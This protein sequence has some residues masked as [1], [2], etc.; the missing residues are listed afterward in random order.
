[1]ETN[2]NKGKRDEP[3]VSVITVVYNGEQHIERT[4]QSVFS[5]SYGNIEYIVIEGASTDTTLTIIRK[6]AAKISHVLSERD[7]GLYHAMNKGI[8][9][10][11]GEIIGILNSGDVYLKNTVKEI[12][13]TNKRSDADIFYGDWVTVKES[14]TSCSYN[15]EYSDMKQM[16]YKQSI[17]HPTCFVKKEVY[18]KKGS[19]DTN[20]RL[21]AD[22]DFLLR[23]MEN[24][25]RFQY[26]P[27]VITACMP[28]GL[29]NS[30]QCDFEA[31]RIQ[32]E[33][34]IPNPYKYIYRGIKCYAKNLMEK[35]LP[36]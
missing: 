24:N 22:Y 15:R 21:A 12:V 10:A 34:R 26:I 1:M 18:N 6:H 11:K 20:Y 30:W 32:K 7:K 5:Q 19:F 25:M 28:G 2:N 31:F 9:L 16:H 36:A 3:L 23:S 13:E 8:T 17:A 33:H 27:K 35:I 29:S 4:L 14:E